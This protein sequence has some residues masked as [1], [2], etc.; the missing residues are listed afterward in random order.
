MYQIT[1]KCSG[2]GHC[3]RWC[4]AGAIHGRKKQRFE[5]DDRC[6]DCG[7]CG[8]VCACGAVLDANGGAVVRLAIKDWFKPVWNYAQCNGCGD[9]LAICPTQ[10]IKTMETSAD[11]VNRSA[12]YPVLARPAMCIGCHFCARICASRAIV[13][14]PG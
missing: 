14:T 13:E 9:C 3:A 7:V 8:R 5:I 12:L 6:I 1:A 10:C 11:I 4:P 2:C